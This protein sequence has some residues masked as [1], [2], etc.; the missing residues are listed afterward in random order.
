MHASTTLCGIML[1]ALLTVAGCRTSH[2]VLGSDSHA[3]IPHGAIPAPLGTY[4]C[5]WQQAQNGLAEQDYFVLYPN[6]WR[7]GANEDGT[8][9]GPAGVRR[10]EE[11]ARR[12]PHE[13]FTV[14]V[15]KSEDADLD[16]ARRVAV[17]SYLSNL[18]MHDADSRVV[19]D[20][21]RANGLYG[22]EAPQIGGGF[23]G[24]GGAGTSGRTGGRGGG[25]GGQNGGQ[26]GFGGGGF[27][28]GGFGGG[29][30]F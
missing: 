12:L 28:G 8:R 13:P 6:E 20:R 30:L 22:L 15:D 9:L 16:Q 2:G 3:D 4:A 5:Q 17:V 14:V 25:L 10:L 1:V 7:Y 19:V 29:G 18:G 11:F 26:G 23:L 21:G 27:G 24:T